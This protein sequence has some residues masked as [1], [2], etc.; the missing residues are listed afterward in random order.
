[1]N[2]E[3]LHQIAAAAS[4][5]LH[6]PAVKASGAMTG[7]AGAM[8]VPPVLHAEPAT[9]WMLWIAVASLG[10]TALTFVV[11]AWQAYRDNKRA[12]EARFEESAINAAR[13]RRLEH[14]L[15]I[16]TGVDSGAIPLE[17]AKR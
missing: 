4:E 12:D 13:L 15:P 9:P 6:A 7:V 1:M 3:Q 8:T 14:G 10:F 2:R 16:P 17:R 5:A 11:K